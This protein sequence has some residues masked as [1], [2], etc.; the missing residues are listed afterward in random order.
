MSL[1]R[2]AWVTILVIVVLLV[3]GFLFT[4]SLDQFSPSPRSRDLSDSDGD[5]IRKPPAFDC[6][7]ALKMHWTLSVEHRRS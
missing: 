5:P 2:I 1:G 4:R 7:G 3:I 6:T